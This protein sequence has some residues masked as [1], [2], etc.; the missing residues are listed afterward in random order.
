MS[1]VAHRLP[2]DGLFEIPQLAARRGLVDAVGELDYCRGMTQPVT[3]QVPRKKK[4]WLIVVIV[5]AGACG[6]LFLIGIP[7]AIFGVRK[8]LISAKSAEGR[9]AVGVLAQGIARCPSATAGRPTLPQTAHAVPANL[10]SVQGMKY[11]SEPA[12]WQDEAYT[13]ANFRISD[14]QY[15]QY[16]W[17]RTSPTQGTVRA[18]ADLD[19]NGEPDFDLEQDVTCA[20]GGACTVGPLRD[21][22]TLQ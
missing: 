9:N 10:A 12:E 20:N 6:F 5:I 1:R 22:S 17:V 2:R 7:L 21:K 19:G 14:P 15:F 18:L 4:T 13:C 3:D 11:Q 16:Q 8:Y